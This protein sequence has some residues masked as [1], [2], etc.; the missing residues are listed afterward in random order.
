[1][2]IDH[3]NASDEFEFE[4]VHI[5]FKTLQT[6]SIK[7]YFIVTVNFSEK[8]LCPELIIPILLSTC[9]VFDPTSATLSAQCRRSPI[10]MAPLWIQTCKFTQINVYSNNHKRQSGIILKPL[11][12][13][14][15]I[16]IYFLETYEKYQS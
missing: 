9:A 13:C 4:N 8:S 3:L 12:E 5:I 2:F 10:K 6:F 16:H 7:L 1:M 11:V 15:S 14:F